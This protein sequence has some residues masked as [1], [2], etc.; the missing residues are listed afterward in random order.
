MLG[1]VEE[2]KR[3]IQRYYNRVF[4]PHCAWLVRDACC[5]GMCSFIEVINR[6][7]AV[8]LFQRVQILVRGS[9]GPA[10]LV[11]SVAVGRLLLP[12]RVLVRCHAG[13]VRCHGL[14]DVRGDG[15]VVNQANPPR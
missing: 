11:N 7:A 13:A 2:Y 8:C 9:F 15:I 14:V 4:A 3:A 5:A 1:L 6:L 12:G 10:N